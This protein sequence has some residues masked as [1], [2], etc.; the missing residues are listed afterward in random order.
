M[1]YLYIEI[2]NL[3]KNIL[4]DTANILSWLSTPITFLGISPLWLF[5]ITGLTTYIAI[6]ITKW[7]IV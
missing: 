7:L 1:E 2:I 6:A 3:S 4:L 5:S